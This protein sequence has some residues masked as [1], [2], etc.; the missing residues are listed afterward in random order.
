MNGGLKRFTQANV[1]FPGGLTGNLINLGLRLVYK[2]LYL[3]LTV[4]SRLGNPG[5]SIDEPSQDCL[6]PDNFGVVASVGCGWDIASQ[7]V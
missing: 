3:A 6:I 7:R 4:I 2:V 5:S 1:I